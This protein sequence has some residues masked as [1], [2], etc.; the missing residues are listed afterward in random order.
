MIS[1]EKKKKIEEIKHLKDNNYQKKYQTYMTFYKDFIRPKSQKNPIK[2]TL[3][4]NPKNND[5]FFYFRLRNKN[6]LIYK[7]DN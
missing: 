3:H 1:P 2:L 5:N 4:K 7:N 6:A